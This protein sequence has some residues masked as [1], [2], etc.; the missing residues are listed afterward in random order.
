VVVNDIDEA[1]N[2]TN[3]FA[4][5]H[6]VLSVAEPKRWLP[7][8]RHAGGVFLGERTPEPLGDYV[9][10]PSHI[11]PT[12][13]NA[14]FTSVLNVYQFLKATAVFD[15]APA[16]LRELGPPATHI[17]HAEGLPAHANAIAVR[18][19]ERPI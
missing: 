13:G 3:E 9:I 4:P 7:L 19:Q 15:A 5:E 6:V 8:I 2:M 17:A 1:I 11:M 10:G 12:A 16:L 18:L 14:R